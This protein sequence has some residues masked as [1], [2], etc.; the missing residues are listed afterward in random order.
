MAKEVRRVDVGS[1]PELLRIAQ[2]V[3]ETGE[4]CLLKQADEELAIITPMTRPSSRTVRRRRSGIIT[5]DDPIWNIVGMGASG[6]PGDISEN[7][8]KYLAEAYRDTHE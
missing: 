4:P 6:G 8:H 7:K 1:V 5:K 2:Q 3:K